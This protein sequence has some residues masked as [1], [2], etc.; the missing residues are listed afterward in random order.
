MARGCSRLKW[1]IVNDASDVKLRLVPVKHARRLMFVF[2]DF[3]NLAGCCGVDADVPIMS[4]LLRERLDM[5]FLISAC[6]P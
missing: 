3:L 6:F 1:R 4:I 2:H 5:R